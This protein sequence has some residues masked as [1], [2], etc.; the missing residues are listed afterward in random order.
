MVGVSSVLAGFTEAPAAGGGGA[1]A[2]AAA[3]G[4]SIF[5]EASERY[6]VESM[7]NIT[8]VE[9]MIGEDADDPAICVRLLKY[10]NAYLERSTGLATELDLDANELACI[11]RFIELSVR[12]SEM[13]TVF[14][15]IGAWTQDHA[16]EVFKPRELLHHD[17]K[18]WN[19]I[20]GALCR[21]IHEEFALIALYARACSQQRC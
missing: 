14:R 16:N 15:Q 5:L 21:M 8:G 19:N 13:E 1:A 4:N 12:K 9:A 3:P 10:V 18:S 2:A 20:G 11:T 7:D 17:E 6:K